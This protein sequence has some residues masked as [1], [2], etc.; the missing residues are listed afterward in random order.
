MSNRSDAGTESRRPRLQA[1]AGDEDRDRS[2]HGRHSEPAANTA[3]QRAASADDR[4][5]HQSGAD[6]EQATEA[7][8]VGGQERRR[9][10]G[11]RSHRGQHPWHADSSSVTPSTS[12]ELHQ[13]EGY[14]RLFIDEV[15][16]KIVPGADSTHIAIHRH[17]LGCSAKTVSTRSNRRTSCRPRPASTCWRSPASS[18]SRPQSASRRTA[19]RPGRRHRVR[20]CQPAPLRLRG[21]GQRRAAGGG[22][23]R[24]RGRGP[25]PLVVPGSATRPATRRR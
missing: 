7:H 11:R 16:E 24:G 21:S 17:R 9:R 20:L 1:T 13:A 22:E 19:P 23:R 2:R 4:S 18:A 15:P 14:D 10:R 25:G 3:S 8:R 12:D 5:G 6:H